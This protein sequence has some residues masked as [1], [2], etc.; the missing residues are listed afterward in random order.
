[1]TRRLVLLAAAALAPAAAL[2]AQQTPAPRAGAR[3]DTST[4]AFD[5]GGV[6]V[7]LRRNPAND[8][9]AANLYLLGGGQMVTPE[10]AGIEPFLLWVSERGTK[11]YSQD[12]LRKKIAALGSTIVVAPSDDW[13]LFGFRGVKGTFDSTWAIWADR[14]TAGTLDPSDIDFVRDQI[15]SALRQRD[16]NADG[17]VHL[18]ADSARFAGM[19]YS[20]PVGGSERSVSS[21]TAAELADWRTTKI[22]TSRMLLVVVGNVERD[23]LARLVAQTFGKIPHG[24]YRW[25]PP[26]ATPGTG[27]PAVL[28]QKR[29]PT[30]YLLGYYIGPPASSSDA[31]ALRIATAVIAGRL[32]TEV[33]SRRNLTYDVDAPF[34]ERAIT[35]GGLYV[36]TAFADSTLDIMR[37]ETEAL[38]RGRLDPEQLNL[39]EQQF[40]TEF[41]LKNETNADQAGQLAR[42]QVYRGDYRYAD[43]FVLDIHAVTPLGI[44]Y[45]AQKY[46]KGFVWAYVGDTLRVTRAKLE[47]F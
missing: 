31:T 22:I 29:L 36:T 33:R 45:V 44:Q 7:I 41:F 3:F 18:L 6:H 26:V 35:T 25:T 12:A 28:A 10:N 23:H 37:R 39:I 2:P 42:A 20:M 5:T 32:F 9:V 27:G 16:D 1:V 11:S 14:L 38:K 46:M 40:I 4:V 30:N 21:F 43:R 13:T 34:E 19:P 24:M 47:Q 15:L 17:L 8:V